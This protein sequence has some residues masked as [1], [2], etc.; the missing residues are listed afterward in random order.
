LVA[1]T[2][3]MAKIDGTQGDIDLG[4]GKPEEEEMNPIVYYICTIA[5]FYAEATAGCIITEH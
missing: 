1:A 4:E 2:G 5:L 3:Q